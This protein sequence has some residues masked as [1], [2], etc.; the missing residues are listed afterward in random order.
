M[1]PKPVFQTLETLWAAM[2]PL[3]LPMAVM[4][5]LALSTWK[6]VR[7]TQDVDLLVGLVDSEPENIVRCVMDHGFRPKRTPPVSPLGPFQVLQLEFEPAESYVDVQVDL[8]LVDSEYHSR[9]L[10]RRVGVQL[11][12]VSSE[13]FVL[14]CEDLIIH[15]LLAGRVIDRADSAALL[16]ANRDALDMQYVGVWLS[17]LKLSGEFRKVWEEAFPGEAPPI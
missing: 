12:D 14:T 7:A 2:E 5:G 4:G 10:E 15:K 16:R 9:A 3:G 11:P 17:Q 13:V 6:H 1:S 8:L